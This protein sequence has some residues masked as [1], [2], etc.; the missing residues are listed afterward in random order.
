MPIPAAAQSKTSVCRRSLA[1]IV[2]LNPAEGLDVC[3]LWALCVVRDR[4]V[5]RADHSSRGVLHSVVCLSVILKPQQREGLGPLGVLSP[6]SKL[7]CTF[8][9]VLLFWKFIFQMSVRGP[10]VII[11]DFLISF[12][13]ILDRYHT[14]AG[15]ASVHISS[16]PLLTYLLTYLLIFVSFTLCN[17][18]GCKRSLNNYKYLLCI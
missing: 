13:Q 5:R 2:G 1:G 6:K 12:Q 10:G 14:H 8:Y 4:S 3:L 17:D 18:K 7:P 16:N 15:A 9:S 11:A